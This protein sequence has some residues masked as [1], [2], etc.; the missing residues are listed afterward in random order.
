MALTRVVLPTPGPP[1]ITSTL[2]RSASRTASRWLVGQADAGPRLDPGDRLVGID[3]AAR[4]GGPRPARSSRS[5]MP[6]SARYSPARNTQARPSTVSATTAPSASSSASAASD[7]LGGISSSSAASV[8]QLV[9]RQAAMALVHGLGQGVADAGPG[10]D[11][12]RLLDP[13]PRRDLVGAPEADAADVAGEA[14]GVLGDHLH[15]IGAVGLED[16]HRP[17]GADAVAVQEQHD[18][19]DHLLLG[20]ARDDPLR[21]AWA[22]CRPPPAGARAAAR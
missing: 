1:V 14:V 3:R 4:A 7:H 21:R 15:G 19:A 13:E 8:A 12:R 18:L 5:A 11:H 22:R 2:E 20:P 9:H 16:P 10:A 6:R 17:R